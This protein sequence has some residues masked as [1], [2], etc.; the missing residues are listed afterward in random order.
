MNT[1]GSF[2]NKERKGGLVGFISSLFGGG[3]SG[4]TSIGAGG[5]FAT[6]AGMLGEIGRAHV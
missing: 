6:K 5:L 4:A 3:G 2:N 1:T